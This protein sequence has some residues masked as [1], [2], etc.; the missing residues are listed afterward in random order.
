VV[1]SFSYLKTLPAVRVLLH[2]GGFLY[3]GNPSLGPILD[4]A[5][6]IGAIN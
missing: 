4:I 5:K 3:G 6:Q 2:P 1:L